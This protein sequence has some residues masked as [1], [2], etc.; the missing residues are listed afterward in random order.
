MGTLIEHEPDRQRFV[1]HAEGHVG[2]LEYR[3]AAPTTLDYHSTYVPPALRGRGVASDL[4]RHALAYAD[5]Q[6]L[7]V[8][9]SCSFVARF[10]EKHPEFQR[11][12]AS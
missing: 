7:E 1:A 11:L 8:V 6:G 12:V 10:I 4:V 9:P 2:R 5:E 3:R